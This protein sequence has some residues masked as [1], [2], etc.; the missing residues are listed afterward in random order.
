MGPGSQHFP[1][2]GAA[3]LEDQPPEAPPPPQQGSPEAKRAQSQQQEEW[4]LQARQAPL[5]LQK[6]TPSLEG[7]TGPGRPRTR[8]A[9]RAP[10]V[11]ASGRQQAG[12]CPPHEAHA[13]AEGWFR[14]EGRIP[15]AEPE[16]GAQTE[17]RGRSGGAEARGAGRALSRESCRGRCYFTRRHGTRFW[18]PRP[19]HGR[20][21]APCRQQPRP[22]MP[23]LPS[24]RSRPRPFR[25]GTGLEPERT[26][27][28]PRPRRSRPLHPAPP[29]LPPDRAEKRSGAPLQPP[30]PAPREDGAHLVRAAETPPR[31]DTAAQEEAPERPGPR[32]SRPPARRPPTGSSRR[33]CPPSAGLRAG[34]R[35]ADA[36]GRTEWT[37]PLS[38]CPQHAGDPF[39]KQFLSP[40]DGEL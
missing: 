10:P 9:R 12:G 39:R 30:G 2:D 11:P 17:A 21:P 38:L 29:P 27:A 6:A 36:A 34:L 16:Q 18:P 19:A 23:P 26:A 1:H 7:P 33:S 31:R 14:S 5:S 40:V 4:G 15:E 24:P 32:E 35:S 8:P 20:R 28:P 37:R 22:W 3:G 25:R 13:K